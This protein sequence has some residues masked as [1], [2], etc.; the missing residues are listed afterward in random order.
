MSFGGIR[1][2]ALSERQVEAV[3]AGTV[4]A[5]KLWVGFGHSFMDQESY[6]AGW[7]ALGTLTW[8]NAQLPGRPLTIA[9]AAGIGGY[10]L[11]DLIT[12]WPQIDASLSPAGVVVSMGH[13]DLK[14]LYPSG[15]A[16]AAGSFP[17]VGA[18]AE[19][20]HLPYL[21]AALRRWVDSVAPSTSI[22][23]LGETPPGQDPTGAAT[24]V[25][26]QLAVRFQQWNRGLMALEHAKRNVIYVPADKPVID[27]TRTDARNYIGMYSDQIHPSIIGGYKRSKTLVKA[28]MSRVPLGTDSLPY[29]A[30][31][32]H[33]NTAMT[34][35]AVPSAAGGVLTIPL[36]NGNARLKTIEVGD[37]VQL[38]PVGTT[39]ADK[40]LAGRYE[41]LTATTTAIT[42]DCSATATASANM[43]VSMSRQLCINPLMLTATGGNAG[44][45][46]NVGTIVGALPLGV[47]VI[48]LPVNWTATFSVEPHLLEPRDIISA[49]TLSAAT[50][51]AG[52]TATAVDGVWQRSDIGKMLISGPGIATVTGI[53]DAKVAVV[54]IT[55]AFAGT[56][57]AAGEG[58]VGER[59]YGNVL[60]I[61]LTS[62]ASGVA[63]SFSLVFQASQK[64][65][66][67]GTYDVF[68]K[69][70]LGTT[71]QAG[72]EYEQTK[73]VGGYNGGHLQLYWRLADV[74]TESAGAN[75][76]IADLFR[77][78]STIPNTTNFSWPADDLRL[79][80]LTP[81]ATP[82]DTTSGNFLDVLQSRFTFFCSGANA[83]ATIRIARSGIWAVDDPAQRGSFRLY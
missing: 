68:R 21:L 40:L 66:S 18:D 82:I 71:Y 15:N 72:L 31:D 46:S 47:D 69:G 25:S 54:S 48:T 79:T 59:G 63:G 51:G 5:G 2:R 32:T 62:G 53:T 37:M 49:V 78:V 12:Y 28:L 36:S 9:L 43:K 81:E 39:A 57:L 26:P 73:V 14:G 64:T 24:T 38:Q 70:H 44:G 4:G 77:E 7:S 27:P 3:A 42:A 13:N 34:T 58:R 19:Q 52:R 60:R 16:S 61:D 23:L 35:T 29:S 8:A 41:V 80:Y 30:A 22:V 1:A 67:P 20:T 45:F 74:A 75:Y 10:R 76:A 11:L 55:T 6:G 56:A 33:T 83:S 50:V 65:A 17:Q